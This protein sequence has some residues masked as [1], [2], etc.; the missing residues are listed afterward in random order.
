MRKIIAAVVIGLLVGFISTT[1][2]TEGP[3][4]DAPAVGESN[5]HCV[6]ITR[7]YASLDDLIH[8]TQNRTVEFIEGFAVGSLISFAVLYVPLR[9]KKHNIKGES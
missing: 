9:R 6:S 3:C 8:N 7:G 4:T 5:S 1:Y 2:H